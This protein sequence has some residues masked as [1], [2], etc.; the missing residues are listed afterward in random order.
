MFDFD[1]LGISEGDDP[2]PDDVLALGTVH[3]GATVSEIARGPALTLAPEV[4]IGAAVE[5]LRRSRRGAAI[6][7]SQQRPLGVVTDHDLLSHA[8]ASQDVAVASVMT[9][10][11]D[12]LRAT[13]TVGAS[14]RRMCE[15]RQWHQAL[16]CERGLLVGAVDIADLTLWLRDRMTL[17]SVDAALGAAAF[18]S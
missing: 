15:A 9:P 11:R 18:G 2:R 1:V 12:P 4:S 17:L 6:I 14:L 5:A 10:C 16:V 13:A 3:L 8:S 7:V